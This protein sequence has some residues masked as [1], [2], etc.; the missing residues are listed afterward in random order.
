MSIITLEMCQPR[1][2]L[3]S[4]AGQ[5]KGQADGLREG[6]TLHGKYIFK[7]LEAHWQ[8]RITTL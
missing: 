2:S 6:A 7:S 8:G 3:R 4:S 5:M 1:Q